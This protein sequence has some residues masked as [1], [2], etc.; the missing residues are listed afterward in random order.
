MRNKEPSTV[1]EEKESYGEGLRS[2]FRSQS[3]ITGS[4]ASEEVNK[5][6]SFVLRSCMTGPLCAF[7]E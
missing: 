3:L 7:N 4:L 2:P 6:P 5:R 1:L